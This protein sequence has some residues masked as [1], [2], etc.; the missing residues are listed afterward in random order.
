M[1]V[2]ELR[3]RLW[4]WTARHPDWTPDDG[5]PD[6]WE[7][8]VGCYSYVS[9]DG[10]TLVLLDPLVPSGGEDEERFWRAL[11]R[12]VAAHGPPHVLLTLFWHARS[13]PKILER[14]DGTRLWAHEPAAQEVRKRTPVTDTF[15]PG[16]ALPA[17]FEA[18]DAGFNME[19]AYR[20]PEY[21]AVVTGDVLIAAPGG[22]VRV[23]QGGDDARRALHPLLEVPVELL[24][25]THGEPVLEGGREALAGALDEAEA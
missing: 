15:A 8:D 10:G 16:D 5:G 22:P 17:G 21:A 7:P 2:R 11:D 19:V 18:Y 1:D 25:L 3:P 4:Y 24:L 6:G 23:W 9:P 20:L 13:A 12:D 14:Y